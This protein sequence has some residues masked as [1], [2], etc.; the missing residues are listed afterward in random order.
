M[1]DP[2]EASNALS[3]A[4]LAAVRIVLVGGGRMGGALL[5]GWL[6]SGLQAR[7][8]TVVD[9]NV[10]PEAVPAGVR[11]ERE[12]EAVLAQAEPDVLVLAVKPQVMDAVASAYGALGNGTTVV[13]SVA[14]GRRIAG[15]EALFGA[16]TP[17]VRSIPNTPAAVHRGM[18]AACANG[19]VSSTQRAVCAALLEA[20]GEVAWVEDEGLIDAVTAVSGSG[21][22]YVFLL[23]EAL[24]QAGARAGLPAPLAERLARV[25]VSGAGALM[26]RVPEDPATLRRNV[27]SPGGTTA[28]ALE[29]LM[30]DPD[31]VPALLE[32]AVAAATARS[33]DLAG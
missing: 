8:L 31:G 33:R 19:R 18:T 24:A 28:A 26:D 9:P 30:A 20:V 21:P 12:P 13:L 27:T 7:N 25:T 10:A 5:T 2:D 15:F 4:S 3:R 32:R 17:V 1:T 14:A 22:A 23:T 11:L 6:E 16:A 29:V